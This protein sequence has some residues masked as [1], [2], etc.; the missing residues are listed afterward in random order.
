[1]IMETETAKLFRA[2]GISA[3]VI[4]LIGLVVGGFY[5]YG[6][7]LDTKYV[8]LQIKQAERDLGIEET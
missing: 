3:G 2:A 6:K 1:M 8:K 4:I 7:I 5:A